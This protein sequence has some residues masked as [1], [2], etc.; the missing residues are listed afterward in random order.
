MN[1]TDS[2]V[3]QPVA[4]PDLS[5]DG[6][7]EVT[8]LKDAQ[9]A[10]QAP[11]TVSRLQQLKE[12]AQTAQGCCVLESLILEIRA[13][14]VL[15]AAQRPMAGLSPQFFSDEADWLAA[16]IIVLGLVVVAVS[17]DQLELL[18]EANLRI[19]RWA[20]RHRLNIVGAKPLLLPFAADELL[21]LKGW[22]A[23]SLSEQGNGDKSWEAVIAGSLQ[24]RQACRAQAKMVDSLPDEFLV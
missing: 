13:V 21:C 3:L 23:Q 20:A 9:V 16:R 7:F 11:A 1:S 22:T 5:L 14:A 12:L 19:Q 6:L 18:R 4:H 2:I 24:V 15:L 8:L 10:S 17:K